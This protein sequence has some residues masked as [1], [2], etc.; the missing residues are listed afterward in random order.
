MVLLTPASAPRT[1]TTSYPFSSS[2]AP[3]RI[4]DQVQLP[5]QAPEPGA[6]SSTGGWFLR[7][8]GREADSDR[9]AMPLDELADKV[10]APSPGE[11]EF[12]ELV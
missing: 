6:K 10:S 2:S 9:A 7:R 4:G 3:L 5:T 1:T 11:S 8:R 12:R